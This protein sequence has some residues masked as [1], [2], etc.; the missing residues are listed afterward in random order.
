VSHLTVLVGIYPTTT[1][2]SGHARRVTAFASYR[3]SRRRVSAG[4][5][6]G[7][8]S[9]ILSTLPI[10]SVADSFGTCTCRRGGDGAEQEHHLAAAA[11]VGSLAAASRWGSTSR[12]TRRETSTA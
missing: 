6:G 11:I 3:Y 2:Y 12:R 1:A 10:A 4:D 9:A 7:S 5:W 8:S